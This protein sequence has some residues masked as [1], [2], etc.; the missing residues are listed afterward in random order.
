M[1]RAL[2]SKNYRDPLEQLLEREA[3]TCKG[4]AFIVKV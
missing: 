4:C 2:P 1:S 3:R